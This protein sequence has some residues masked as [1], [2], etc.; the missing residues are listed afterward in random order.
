MS[1][2]MK[3]GATYFLLVSVVK[4]TVMCF[5]S[6]PREAEY[7][8]RCYEYAR[9]LLEFLCFSVCSLTSRRLFDTES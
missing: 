2:C 4:V 7:L 1:K 5:I 9:Y 8:F 6:L 3:R